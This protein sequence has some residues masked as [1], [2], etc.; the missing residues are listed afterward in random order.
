M[1]AAKN[2][3]GWYAIGRDDIIK[4]GDVFVRC[5]LGCSMTPENGEPALFGMGK[6][7]SHYLKIS[8]EYPWRVY[9]KG[10]GQ[11]I[12]RRLRLN[13]HFSKQLPLP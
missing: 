5:S 1:I 3:A 11:S 6:T 12:Q 7:L 9:R 2:F 4:A 13:P 8:N 10:T